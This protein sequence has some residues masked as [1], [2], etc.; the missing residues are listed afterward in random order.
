M[1]RFYRLNAVFFYYYSP[2]FTF[3]L[4][5]SFPLFL[6]I[7]LKIDIYKLRLL[8]IIQCLLWFFFFALFVY[9]CVHL[10]LEKALNKKISMPFVCVHM[11]K[12]KT[13]RERGREKLLRKILCVSNQ[14]SKVIQFEL[15]SYK[16]S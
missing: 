14:N 16:K 15:F 8:H 1:L 3:S 10:F 4:S 11:S 13:E 2:S 12:K 9:L 6:S 5:L 7:A